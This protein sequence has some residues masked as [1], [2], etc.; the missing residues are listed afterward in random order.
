MEIAYSFASS[1]SIDSVTVGFFD[2]CHL[3]HSKLLSVL[4]SY[5]GTSGIITFDP[6]PQAILSSP[7]KL[8]TNRQE[9]LK[10]L[11]AFPIDFLCILSFD[12][13]LANQSADTFISSLHEQL[14]FK[15]LIL[16]HDS[17]LGKGGQGNV[18]TLIP[19]G[20]SLG[21]EIV[22]VSPCY[23]DGI[24]VSSNR[25]RNLLIEG[26]LELAYRYL[27]YPYTF[28][29]KVAEGYGIGSDLGFATIN[30]PREES[31]LPL[32]VYACEICHKNKNYL[33][34]MNLGIAPTIKRNSLCV[35]AHL[36]NFFGNLYDEEVAIIPRK[37]LRKEKKFSSRVTLVNAIR[38][39]I[40]NAQNFFKNNTFNY[41]RK[42]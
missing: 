35:E 12:F 20:K 4:T 18:N 28:L 32:G 27:G 31:L 42:E 22:Q 8:I 7:P 23:V 33:G 29:G 6:H 17:R 39:D 10:L 41:V 38:Q 34:V 15:R 14:K 30:L 1:T 37:F 26:H 24:L 25:V 16:G 19:L 40:S 13:K 2:G 5:P 11:Q 21:I 36:F 9:R 3:G